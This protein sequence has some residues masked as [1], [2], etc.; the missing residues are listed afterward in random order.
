MKTVFM[1][2]STWCIEVSHTAENLARDPRD[3]VSEW[4]LTDKIAAVV[5]YNAN[6]IVK[7]ANDINTDV[8]GLFTKS[9]EIVT[10]LRHNPVS[11]KLMSICFANGK[12]WSK[13]HQENNTG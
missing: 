9:R 6:N 7:A 13:L 11:V 3:L 8:F 4:T 12:S 2:L 5:T 1:V 10:F